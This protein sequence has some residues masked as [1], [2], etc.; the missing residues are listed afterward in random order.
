MVTT[1]E[2][3]IALIKISIAC[4]LSKN[5]MEHKYYNKL[6]NKTNI[7]IKT[8]NEKYSTYKL[9]SQSKL[10]VSIFSTVTLEALNFN[11]KIRSLT[12]T[13]PKQIYRKIL[14][15]VVSFL[16]EN[17]FLDLFNLISSR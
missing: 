16:V 12:I 1:I 11:K 17:I 3:V 4:R 7:T 13:R 15:S 6:L 14:K 8:K 2:S 10:I 9:V 5:S